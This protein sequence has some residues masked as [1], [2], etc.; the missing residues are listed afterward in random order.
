M[1]EAGP[2]SRYFDVGLGE[3]FFTQ[4]RTVTK[5][6]GLLWAMYTGGMHPMHVDEVYARDH[7]IF[8]GVFALGLAAVAI[9][10]GLNERLGLFAGTSFAITGQTIRYLTPVLPGD[11]IRVRLEVTGLIAH[12]RRQAGTATFSYVIQKDDGV[13]GVEGDFGMFL[14]QRPLEEPESQTLHEA[15]D[16]GC[17]RPLLERRGL[18]CRSHPHLFVFLAFSPTSARASCRYCCPEA[19]R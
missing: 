11:T 10:S 17:R 14:A 12:P 3:V 15:D 8:G 13:P 16:S 5:T 18:L 4:G 7:G 1:V 19:G 6:D 2:N 9:A